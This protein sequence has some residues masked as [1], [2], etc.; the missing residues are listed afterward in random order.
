MPDT[1]VLWVAS[2]TQTIAWTST[3]E[4]DSVL[5]EYQVDGGDWIEIVRAPNTGT[6]VWEVPE[7]AVGEVKLRIGSLSGEF[8][9]ESDEV[10]EVD[11][12]AGVLRVFLTSDD[13]VTVG[14]GE[15]FTYAGLAAGRDSA[16][17]EFR[18]I[19]F[20][21][22]LTVT[23]SGLSGTA[24]EE[25]GDISFV[26]IASS[27]KHADTMEVSLTIVDVKDPEVVIGL[28]RNAAF[29][30]A[31]DVFIS[32]SEELENISGEIIQ[33]SETIDMTINRKSPGAL[34]YRAHVNGLSDSSFRIRVRVT[35]LNGNQ[36]TEVKNIA[37]I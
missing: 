36:A 6:Y 8:I 13:S 26:V 18:Y 9:D 16:E 1:G 28:Y 32:V 23:D 24:P 22:W 2:D 33:D 15:V 35:D 34:L 7:D 37:G 11:D 20:P 27:G 29:P 21:S 3:G 10:I 12:P 4:L 19:S 14:Q 25:T 30:S 17:A 5:I 31:A